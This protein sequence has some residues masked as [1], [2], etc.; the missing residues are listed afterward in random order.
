MYQKGVNLNLDAKN[1]TRLGIAPGKE[2]AVLTD[3]N[4]PIEVI[5]GALFGGTKTLSLTRREDVTRAVLQTL[6]LTYAPK[7]LAESIGAGPTGVK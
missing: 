7:G 1:L 6:G 2:V 3:Y 4:T 5:P